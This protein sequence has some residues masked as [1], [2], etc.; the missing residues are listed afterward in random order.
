MRFQH[1]PHGRNSKG[2][3]VLYIYLSTFLIKCLNNCML[4]EQWQGFT[5]HCVTSSCVLYFSPNPR[6]AA[7]RLRQFL[8]WLAAVGL[9]FF[10]SWASLNFFCCGSNHCSSDSCSH[11]GWASFKLIS[12]TCTGL[13]TACEQQRQNCTALV[14]GFLADSTCRTGVDSVVR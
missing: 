8:M 4:K 9:R 6:V 10:Y 13:E 11:N 3:N 1:I 2:L 12:K 7:D 5:L 14:G